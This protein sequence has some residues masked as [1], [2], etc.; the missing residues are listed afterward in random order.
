VPGEKTKLLYFRD[1]GVPNS[2]TESVYNS[3]SVPNRN[4][5]RGV[6]QQ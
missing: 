3:V 4:R 6:W 1:Y 2:Q 5:G